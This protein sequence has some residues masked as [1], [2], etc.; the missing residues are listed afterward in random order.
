MLSPGS[1][2]IFVQLY[3]IFCHFPKKLELH[4]HSN[5]MA[6]KQNFFFFSLDESKKTMFH[7]LQ[8]RRQAGS[9][10]FFQSQ[11]FVSTATCQNFQRVE[12]PVTHSS[13]LFFDKLSNKQLKLNGEKILIKTSIY[14]PFHRK[15]KIDH[16]V[17]SY[18]MSTIVRIC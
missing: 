14:F 8:H 12:S 18:I 6:K 7:W 11:F 16:L 3:F 5:E 15:H 2:K 13:Q 1:R 4:F 17:S 9:K 10:H